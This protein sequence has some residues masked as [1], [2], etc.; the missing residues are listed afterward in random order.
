M[1]FR[2]NINGCVWMPDG[3]RVSGGPTYL[4]VLMMCVCLFFFG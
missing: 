3:Q 2:S 4:H 1:P